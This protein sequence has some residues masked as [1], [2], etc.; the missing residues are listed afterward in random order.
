MKPITNFEDRPYLINILNEKNYNTDKHTAHKYI[1]DF[2]EKEFIPFQSKNISLLE[3]G[4]LDGERLKLWHDYFH[5]KKNIVGIDIFIRTNFDEIKDRLEN[6]D[7]DLY[8]VDSFEGDGKDRDE[9]KRTFKEGFDIIIDD[10]LHKDYAQIETFNNFQELMN[11]GGLYV[12]EDINRLEVDNI[13][14]N[15][16]NIEIYQC[17]SYHDMIGNYRQDYGVIRF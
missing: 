15:I 2:Y 13:K 14:S 5:N 12:I 17:D 8:K 11:P 4:V 16:K 6:F 10:G 3:I 1:Q 9:F 7:I